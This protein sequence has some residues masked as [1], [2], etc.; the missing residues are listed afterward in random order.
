MDIPSTVARDLTS[1]QKAEDAYT[2][3]I[4]RFPNDPL[5]ED[6]RKGRVKTRELLAE[7]ELYIGNFYSNQDQL[8]SAKGR[9]E[10]L[11]QLYPETPQAKTAADL[12]AKTNL[13]LSKKLK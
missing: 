4:K 2:L 9:Y 10:K 11:I 8:D 6:A 1:A 12:L 13:K 5:I 3:F 7:K